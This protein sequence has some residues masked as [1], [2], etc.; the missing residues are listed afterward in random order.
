[1]YW[2]QVSCHFLILSVCHTYHLLM[3]RREK[4]SVVVLLQQIQ[5]TSHRDSQVCI[6]INQT[7]WGKGEEAFVFI[8]HCTCNK[9]NCRNAF[10]FYPV[11]N[12]HQEHHAVARSSTI[13]VWI[14]CRRCVTSRSNKVNEPIPSV[15]FGNCLQN[16]HP[17]NW[18]ILRL[19]CETNC[20]SHIVMKCNPR[21]SQR[22][23]METRPDCIDSWSCAR[24]WTVKRLF[25]G[26]RLTG[27]WLNA[28]EELH[29]R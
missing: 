29:L 20:K 3:Q 24:G 7:A 18:S 27:S 2:V 23:S 22:D 11:Q 26:R 1:M 9:I 8:T 5:N 16:L 10:S 28:T 19:F 12:P 21:T 6:L 14:P 13:A 4:L 15:P 17:A 25:S